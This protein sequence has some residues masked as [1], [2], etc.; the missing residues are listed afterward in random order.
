[1]KKFITMGLATIMA[2]S[3]AACGGSSSSSSSSSASTSA[4]GKTGEKVSLNLS[5][6]TSETSTW[7]QA[8]NKFAEDVAAKTDGNV[9]IKVYPNEQLSGGNQ[10]K[11]IEMLRNGSMDIGFYANGNYS[12]LDERFITVNLPFMFKNAEEADEV[13]AGE[14]GEKYKEL[15]DE[16]NVTALGFGENGFRQITNSVRPIENVDDIKGMKIRIPT[17]KMYISLYKALGA[18]PISMNFSEVFTSLQQGA[19]DGQENPIDTINSAKLQ[20]VQKY[21]SIWDYSYDILIVGMNKDKFNSLPEEYQQVLTECAE[22]AC[23]YQKQLNRDSE[24]EKLDGF[25]DAGMTISRL[26]DEQKEA[27]KEACA[28]VYEEYEPI[29]GKDFIDCFRK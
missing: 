20:E 29:I 6:T 12:V 28:P 5:V 21:I 19:I 8:A 11:G 7:T 15:C 13:M 25:E 23:E 18:N 3:L 2:L 10:A 24:S 14:G 16:Q 22:D 1:M 27:F 26:T 4:A 17:I 9:E